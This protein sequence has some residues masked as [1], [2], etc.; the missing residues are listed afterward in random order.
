[1]KQSEIFC[2]E[3]YHYA[4]MLVIQLQ[5]VVAGSDRLELKRLFKKYHEIYVNWAII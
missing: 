1:M 4:I 3:E 5:L 2:R